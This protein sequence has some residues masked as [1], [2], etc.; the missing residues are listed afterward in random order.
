MSRASHTTKLA[1][2][3]PNRMPEEGQYLAVQARDARFDGRFFTAVTSTGIYCRPVCKVRAPK[4]EN[5]HFYRLAA[6]A[7]AAGF[8]PC[9]R[10]RPEL[11]PKHQAWSIQDASRSLAMAAVR[12]LDDPAC[13]L[14]LPELSAHLGVSPRHLRRIFQ[15]HLGVSPLQYL[16]TRRLLAAKQLLCDTKLPMAAVALASGFASVRRFHAVFGAQYGFPPNR[17]RMDPNMGPDADATEGAQRA[18]RTKTSTYATVRLAYRPPLD[19]SALLD[20][21]LKRQVNAIEYVANNDHRSWTVRTFSL[22]TPKKLHTGWVQAIFCPN[23]PRVNLLVGQ[24]LHSVLPSVINRAR[25][26]L[27]LDADP[28]AIEAALGEDFPGQSGLRV[29]GALDGFEIAVRAILGQQVTVAAGRTFCA[30]LVARYGQPVSADALADL[31]RPVRAHI[32]S[33]GHTETSLTHTFPTAGTLSRARPED[34]GALGLVRQRQSAIIALAHAVDAGLDLSPS[35]P[36][37]ATLAAL[38]ALPGIGEWT[39]QYIAMRAL[40]WPDAWPAGD[41][42]LHKRLGI[43]A[44]GHTGKTAAALCEA[45]SQRWRPWR[46][47]A[48][49]RSWAQPAT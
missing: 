49:V 44:A 37:E 15:T 13:V 28:L 38:Q 42:V 39:A 27:D 21:F 41:V 17:L 31:P 3:D 9:L 11:A 20:F 1:Q 18:G 6:Q 24:S 7:E 45:A 30:R 23:A 2:A 34:L 16:Q 32:Q 48:V 36:L 4:P 12:L 19:A 25:A 10:C 22:Q 26:W 5:C 46:S 29:P 43:Q 14:A 35:A 33:Q 47:Y 8:R 40:R